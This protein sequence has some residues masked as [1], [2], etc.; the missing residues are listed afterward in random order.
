MVKRT[1]SWRWFSF[2]PIDTCWTLLSV[3]YVQVLKM[4]KKYM[5]PTNVTKVVIILCFSTGFK[6]FF[7]GV[8]L[9]QPK[10]SI[11]VTPVLKNLKFSEINTRIPETLLTTTTTIVPVISDTILNETFTLKTRKWTGTRS[12][13]KV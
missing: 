1:I 8:F 5:S 11:A 3:S 10:N 6:L 12:C 13:V 7:E 4:F 2:Q 9:N